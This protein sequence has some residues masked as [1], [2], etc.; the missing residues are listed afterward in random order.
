MAYKGTNKPLSQ[1]ARDLNVDAVVEGTV[2]RS[3]DRSA[4]HEQSWFKWPRTATSGRRPMKVS[5]KT[6]LHS[7]SRVAS[8]IVNEIR[9]NLTR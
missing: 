3:G 2:L 9:V 1:I 5:W 8:A 4:D 7:Q 6:S